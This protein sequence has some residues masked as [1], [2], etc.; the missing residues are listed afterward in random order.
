MRRA[1]LMMAATDGL[2]RSCSCRKA[3]TAALAAA[4]ER[5]ALGAAPGQLPAAPAAEPG[6]WPLPPR[7]SRSTSA[8]GVAGL[9]EGAT[10]AAVQGLA[11]VLELPD[12]GLTSSAPPPITS[13]SS[14]SSAGYS[15]GAVAFEM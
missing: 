9:E 5:G 13:S 2:S 11:T 4:L 8:D 14:R 12:D 1:S 15:G 7:A 3:S 10:P 6:V